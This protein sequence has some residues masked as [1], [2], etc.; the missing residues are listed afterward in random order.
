[1]YRS[2]SPLATISAAMLI[3]GGT[4]ALAQKPTIP[5]P[6]GNAIAS[7]EWERIYE[8]LKK[9]KPIPTPPHTAR[10]TRPTAPGG[11]MHFD[12]K[13][14][15]TRTVPSTPLFLFTVP[16]HPENPGVE[17]KALH[18]GALGI[19]LGAS[20]GVGKLGAAPLNSVIRPFAATA[21][22]PLT[23][24][25][26]FPWKTYARILLRFN[27]GGADYYYLCSA[28]TTSSFHMVSAGH[29]VYS[30][31]IKN[32]GSNIAG[33]AAEAWAWVTETDVVDPID[34]TNWPDFPYGVA[35]VNLFTTYNNWINSSDLNWDFSFLTMDRRIGDHVGWIGREWNT[36]TA[37]LNF[38]GYPA[39]SPYVPSDNPFQYPGYD[40][41]NVLGYTCC[42]IQLSAF[43][44]G[45]HSGGP[46]WR[47]DGTNRYLEG[48]N[49]TSD[50][51][52]YAEATLLTSQIE[53]DLENH[54]NNDG[55]PTDLAQVIENVFDGNE[56]GLGQTSTQIGYSFP[57]T[58][59]A[60]N[61]GYADAGDTTADIYL[62]NDPNNVASGTFI[63]THDFGYL[64]TYTLTTQPPNIT[65]PTYVTPGTYY[66][67]YILNAANPQYN[68]D[69]NAVVITN[70]TMQAYCNAD[71]F[72]PDNAWFQASQLFSGG[73]QSHSICDNNLPDPRADQD[74]AYFTVNYTSGATI[75]TN[76][77]PGG[78]TTMT[79]Y[80]GN[81]QQVDFNDDNGI[82]FY[83]TINRVCG[84]NA[85]P[86]GT[87]YVQIQSYQNRTTIPN[88]T[89]NL[90]ANP[91]PVATSTTLVG[92][93]NPSFYGQVVTY[94][95]TTSGG[96]TPTGT[97]SF[98]DGAINMGSAALVSG[99]A[100]LNLTLPAGSHSITAV[101]NPNVP[102]TTSTSAPLVV[103]VNKAS[104]FG[105]V[106]S[107]KN[108]SPFGGMVTFTA[109]IQSAGGTPAG[110]VTFKDGASPLSPAVMLSGG[111]ATFSTSTLTVGAHSITAV[112]AAT[113]NFL[114]SV[115]PVLT[116]IVT[117]ASSTT[118]LAASANPV[119]VG[120]FVTYT[121]TVT[122]GAA[123]G[124]VTFKEGNTAIGPPVA[125][126]GGKATITTKYSAKGSHSITAVYGGNAQY[127]GS[128][129][130]VLNETVK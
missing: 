97:I 120:V 74:W 23:T 77:F 56:K 130:T 84:T 59:N 72:E 3:S 16:R 128:T 17:P 73:S 87:Y 124:S 127:T 30:H 61:A 48:V 91:C 102:W 53:S 18:G 75:W 122:P 20:E 25:Y 29:C 90:T 37:S 2:F 7:S 107:S 47:F 39:E 65:I 110:W 5:V 33:W 24:P 21:P 60:F 66:V 44:Y 6:G 86:P 100:A 55:R 88:Y 36:Q 35:K 117:K 116:E 115:S 4:L 85:L 57:L 125:L 82:N 111:V 8:G 34:H 81:L 76:G 78:D 98:Y 62:S 103:T 51:M 89:L 105:G 13:T 71:A 112:Y 14:R 80:N 38:D 108:P 32:D 28:S 46:V 31:D 118:S 95:A 1:M 123:T 93:K 126:S 40:A 52:G 114:G 22:G 109:K 113:A 45:G 106:T 67:G 58:L 10:P 64:G 69:R 50:R 83:S 12:P 19:A 43:T 68:T 42:R 121:A 27:T 70:Q 104:T 79:L 96:G 9:A 49:S 99:H 26:G 54:I 11:L 94:T 129:S 101:Y 119:M 63:G 41:N 15:G 92:S